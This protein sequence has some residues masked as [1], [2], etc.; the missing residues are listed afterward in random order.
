MNS[1]DKSIWRCQYLCRRTKLQFFKALI[2]LVLLYGSETWTS[3]CALEARLEA[4]CNRS[5]CWIMGYCWRDHVS[6]QRLH[7]ETGTGPVICTICDRQLRLYGHLA[8]FPQDD[9]AHQVVSVRDNP[10]WRRPVG[11]PRKSWLGQIDQTCRE[12]RKISRVPAWRLAMRD[13]RDWKRRMIV[14]TLPTS[15]EHWQTE[16]AN[17]SQPIIMNRPAAVLNVKIDFYIRDC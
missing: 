15:C 9:P 5:L 12:E 3:S 6:N 2:M 16:V 1:L 10:G 8:H 17:F 14:K 7:H 11:Q 4:F 13:P